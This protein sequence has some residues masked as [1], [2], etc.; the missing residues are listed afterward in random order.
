M[1]ACPLLR[2]KRY[3]AKELARCDLGQGEGD[4]PNE[5]CNNVARNQ[6]CTLLSSQLCNV[7]ALGSFDSPITLIDI[8]VSL[9]TMCHFDSLTFFRI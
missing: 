7:R 2:L 8:I 5:D 3:T 9:A 1:R 4:T 6:S